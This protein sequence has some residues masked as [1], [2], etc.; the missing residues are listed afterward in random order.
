MTEPNQ[1]SKDADHGQLLVYSAEDG[2][3][4]IDVRLEGGDGLD[5]TAA[6]G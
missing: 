5:D 4:K 6:H 1:H 3:L 2:Q